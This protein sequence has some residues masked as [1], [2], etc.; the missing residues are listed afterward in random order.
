MQGGLDE[1]GKRGECFSV[2]RSRCSKES[3]KCDVNRGKAT[4]S[5]DNKPVRSGLP[6]LDS[7]IIWKWCALIKGQ[8]EQV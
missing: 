7:V 1:S 8:A 5:A 4:G 6:K 3:L 2:T